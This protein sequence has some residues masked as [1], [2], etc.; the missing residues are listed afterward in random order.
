MRWIYYSVDRWVTARPHPLPSP[1]VNSHLS[2]YP[3]PD[4]LQHTP[5]SGEHTVEVLSS[6]GYDTAAIAALRAKGVV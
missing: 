5:E 2:R 6:L 4:K 3:Q 1:R